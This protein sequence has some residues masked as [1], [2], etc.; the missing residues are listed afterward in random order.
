MGSVASRGT[1]LKAVITGVVFYAFMALLFRPTFAA[2]FMAALLI[3]ELGHLWAMKLSG[4]RIRGLYFIPMVGAAAVPEGA[5]TSRRGEA[6]MSI[7]GPVWGFVS[8]LLVYVLYLVFGAPQ[9]ALIAKWVAIFNLFNLMP[10]SPLDGGRVVKSLCASVSS[11]AGLVF[12]A[13]GPV[14]ALAAAFYTGIWLLGLVAFFA[15]QEYK[16]V[17]YSQY[18]RWDA[19]AVANGL[20]DEIEGLMEGIDPEKDGMS[21]FERRFYATTNDGRFH[22]MALK[23]EAILSEKTDRRTPILR[24]P[25]VATPEIMIWKPPKFLEYLKLGLSQQTDDMPRMSVRQIWLY[26]AWYLALAGALV[27]VWLLGGAGSG[28]LTYMDLF[29][30]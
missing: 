4:M 22:D 17:L 26:G 12:L 8:A 25:F 9:L 21:Q 2:V 30:L 16:S 29:S 18:V 13:I 24:M 11:K 28:T 14:I 7:M 23:A 15:Y 19:G 27:A 3:H 1:I 20:K 10:V 5:F 6:F